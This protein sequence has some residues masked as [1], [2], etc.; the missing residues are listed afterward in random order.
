MQ[1]DKDELRRE[2]PS[3]PDPD[4][5]GPSTWPFG[6]T[7]FV[8]PLRAFARGHCPD[9]SEHLPAVTIHLAS[10]EALE[11]CHVAGLAPGF[12]ALAIRE[13]VTPSGQ[14]IMRT[15]LVPYG[16]ISRVT[17]RPVADEPRQVGFNSE[18]VPTVLSVGSTTPEE[19]LRCA[20]SAPKTP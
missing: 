20:A 14:T 13:L 12:A 7:F 16:L 19:I 1:T 18:H 9:P 15:E 10:G 17:I 8:G 6:P 3:P 4:E 11:L 5:E 2:N